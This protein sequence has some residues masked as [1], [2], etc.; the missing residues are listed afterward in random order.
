MKQHACSVVLA[1]LLLTASLATF[2]KAP[3]GGENYANDASWS[4]EAFERNFGKL[5]LAGQ[6]IG[7]TAA[8]LPG[9]SP[10]NQDFAALAWAQYDPRPATQWTYQI[11][12]SLPA[13][14]LTALQSVFFGLEAN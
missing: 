2:A 11:D 6:R 1:I 4:S 8:N 9:Q 7:Y 13:L 5:T 3:I 12:I 10:S 14:S